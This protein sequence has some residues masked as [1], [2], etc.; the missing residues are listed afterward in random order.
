MAFGSE[1]AHAELTTNL[2][3]IGALSTQDKNNFFVEYSADAQLPT[4]ERSLHPI[5]C[6]FVVAYAHAEF[7][8]NSPLIRIHCMV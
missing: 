3:N 1:Y 7:A 2:Q 5:L 6:L 8:F 4:H